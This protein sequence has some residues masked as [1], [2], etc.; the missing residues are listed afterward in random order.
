LEVL[1]A[2]A[3]QKHIILMDNDAAPTT[4]WE[5]ADLQKLAQQLSYATPALAHVFSEHVSYVN[6]GIMVFPRNTEP[7]APE[8]PVKSYEAFQERR[9]AVFRKY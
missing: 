2:I 4:L 3:P 9:P 1:A 6:A 8:G 5:V 7:N